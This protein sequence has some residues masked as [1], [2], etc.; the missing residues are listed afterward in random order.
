MQP[1]KVD[2]P[3]IRAQERQL[4]SSSSSNLIQ[5]QAIAALVDRYEKLIVWR[6][7]D[8]SRVEARAIPNASERRELE[9]R[10][11]DLR[12]AL[13][14]AGLAMADRERIGAAVARMFAGYPS[15]RNSDPRATIATYVL[16]LESLPA[17][18][19]EKACE[20]VRLGKVP[21]LNPDF[22]PSSVR[23][24]QIALLELEVAKAEKGKI[25][26]LLEVVQSPGHRSE[27]EQ[28]QAEKS[29]AAWLER[30][31]PRAKQL[32]EINRP[33]SE[34]ELERRRFTE[35]AGREFFLRECRAEGIDPAR[36]VSPSLLKTLE[37]SNEF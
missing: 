14:P 3:A 22:P 9:Q 7:Q 17:W 27:A 23:L 36:G 8:G 32:A 31:D 11:A 20:S 34:A 2:I 13:R 37:K 5:A 16:E 6:P 29:A 12:S 26:A 21:E 1:M 24:N 35:E 15:Q 10:I 19:V 25:E 28:A 18:A 30:R 4:A 33:S